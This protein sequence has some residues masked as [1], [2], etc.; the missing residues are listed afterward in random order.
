[1]DLREVFTL[2]HTVSLSSSYS[3]VRRLPVIHRLAFLLSFSAPRFLLFSI[4]SR[5]VL[6]NQIPRPGLKGFLEYLSKLRFYF[7]HFFLLNKMLVS[8][9]S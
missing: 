5:S 2:K 9:K 3:V 6:Y 7:C 4:N 8:L 1:M